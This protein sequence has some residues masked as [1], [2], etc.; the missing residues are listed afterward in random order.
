MLTLVLNSCACV[1]TLEEVLCL[2]VQP[3]ICE[4]FKFGG[5]ARKKCWQCLNLVVAP[6]SV[7]RHHKL[8]TRVYQGALPSSRLRYLN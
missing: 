1:I 5:M 4:V 6:L 8:C 3:E 7:L 2:T